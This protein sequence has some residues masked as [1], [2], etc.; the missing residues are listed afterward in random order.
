MKNLSKL[1]KKIVFI[2]ILFYAIITFCNQQKIL[3]SYAAQSEELES[4]IEKANE[5]KKQLNEEK[6]NVTSKEYIESMAREKLDMYLPN[7]R[8]YVDNK[9]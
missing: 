1:L 4:Q 5:Y 3:N 2:V 9:N 7:E 6:D 8:V